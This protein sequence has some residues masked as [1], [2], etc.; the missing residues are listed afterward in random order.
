MSGAAGLPVMPPRPSSPEW[1]TPYFPSAEQAFAPQ[2]NG[3]GSHNVVSKEA[4]LR[5]SPLEWQPVERSGSTRMTSD[6]QNIAPTLRAGGNPSS[7]G[8]TE[9]GPLQVPTT[10]G[11]LQR[12]V[13]HQYNYS[14]LVS[15]LQTLGYSVA[16][17][18]AAAVVSLEGQPIA[19][20]AVE[21][22]DISRICKQFSAIL[23]N[24]GQSLG[25]ERWGAYEHMIITSADRCILMRMAGGE[26]AFQVL[27]T[28]RDTDP[29]RSLEMMV[30]VE[31]AINTA[32]Q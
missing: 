1:Q 20:V 28:T 22:L 25:Q 29:T 5:P 14:A 19:Q 17:F 8:V 23:K 27:I 32:F 31:G 15:A 3:S 18:V 26:R 4:E 11:N 2:M 16:G 12:V 21:D 13:H 24:V 30:N 10:T 7:P 9:S 6:L